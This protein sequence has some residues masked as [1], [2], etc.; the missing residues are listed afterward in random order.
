MIFLITEGESIIYS[1]IDNFICINY[2]GILQQ[3][4][5]AYDKTFEE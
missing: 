5:S 3:K 2:M 4:L 1:F